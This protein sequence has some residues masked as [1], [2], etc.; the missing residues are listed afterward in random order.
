MFFF[1]CFSIKNYPCFFAELRFNLHDRIFD[2]DEKWCFNY[3][4]LARLGRSISL[5]ISCKIIWCTPLWPTCMIH[6]CSSQLIDPAQS[7][8]CPPWL[9][10]IDLL[11]GVFLLH[12][13]CRILQYISSIFITN[14]MCFPLPLLTGVVNII[15]IICNLKI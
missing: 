1:R 8:R 14:F 2:A 13:H 12:L 11:Y 9:N 7:K 5:V 15:T 3:W 4:W 6:L 10:S